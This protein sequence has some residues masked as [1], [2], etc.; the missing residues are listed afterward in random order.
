MNQRSNSRSVHRKSLGLFLQ[1][2]SGVFSIGLRH[3]DLEES[4]KLRHETGKRE[5]TTR[6]WVYELPLCQRTPFHPTLSLLDLGSGALTSF[7]Q[8]FSLSQ[9]GPSCIKPPLV[10]ASLSLSLLHTCAHTQPGDRTASTTFHS[11]GCHGLRR[12][13]PSKPPNISAAGQTS[14]PLDRVGPNS[15]LTPY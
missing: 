4:L 1:H 3:A 13:S 6:P 7:S 9:P 11:Q 12:N 14:E 2:V 15:I 8:L 10:A 5:S